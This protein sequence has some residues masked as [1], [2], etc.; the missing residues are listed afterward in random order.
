[1]IRTRIGVF[2]FLWPF[3]SPSAVVHAWTLP[4]SS[5]VAFPIAAK[6]GKRPK[7]A[8]Q[9]KTKTAAGVKRKAP[10]DDEEV[11]SSDS[12]SATLIMAPAASPLPVKGSGESGLQGAGLTAEDS[13]Q[14]AGFTAKSSDDSGLQG[15]GFT[16]KGSDDSG[17]QGAGLTAKMARPT[18]PSQEDIDAGVAMPVKEYMFALIPYVQAKLTTFLFGYHGDR[19]A[20]NEIPPFQ[21]SADATKTLKNFKEHW[22]MDRCM[23][24]LTTTQMYEASGNVFWL[25]V[26]GNKFG[27]WSI[28]D[29]EVTW[30]QLQIGASV[31]SEEAL[32]SSC[33]DPQYRR[34][35]FPGYLP[36]VILDT[37]HIEAMQKAKKAKKL[38]FEALQIDC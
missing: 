5:C 9:P 24:S 14:G 12:S 18:K 11:Q 4:S 17:L 35:I 36:S 37:S 26:L 32:V 33:E 19:G 6:M 16:A 30:H 38:I 15:A 20:L 8:A 22:R 28:G 1:M 31:W 2:V 7:A 27:E 10:D 13:L 3:C 29:V 25:D 23:A 34:F 21:I